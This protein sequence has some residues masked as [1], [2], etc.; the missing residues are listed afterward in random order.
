MHVV[1]DHAIAKFVPSGNTEQFFLDV[2]SKMHPCSVSPN[3]P[4]HTFSFFSSDE[5]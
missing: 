2:S 3:K 4:R 1:F 5:I